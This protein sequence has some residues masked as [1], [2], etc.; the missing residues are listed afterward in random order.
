MDKAL[1]WLICGLVAYGVGTEASKVVKRE[2][3]SIVH[4]LEVMAR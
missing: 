3:A 2:F 1:V 4:S